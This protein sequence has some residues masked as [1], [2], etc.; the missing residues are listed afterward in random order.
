VL[1]VGAGIS[2]IQAAL[3]LAEM[4]VEVHLV[5]QTPSIGGR[6]PQLDKTFP[7]NDC[8]ICILAPKMTECARHPDIH[9]HPYSKLVSISGEP[10]NFECT[11]KEYARYVDP[12]KC[13]ACGN[14]EEKCPVKIVDEFDMGLRQRKVIY[15]YF[16][17]SVP[18]NYVIDAEHCLYLNKGV[19]RLCEK[20][21]PANAIKF[22]DEDRFIKINC[23]AIIIATGIDP[24]LPINYGQYGYRHFKDVVTSIEFERMLSASGPQKGHIIRPSDGTEP[25]RI[26]FVQC[27]GSRDSKNGN[28][29]C[30]SVCCMYAIKQAVIAKE[31][32]KEIEP[33]IFFMDIRAFG[34]DFD[35]YYER[36]KSQFG[37]NFVRARVAKITQDISNGNRLRL[38]FTQ[39]YGKRDSE[40]FDLVILSVGLIPRRSISE[41]SDRTDIRLDQYGFCR[42]L[43]FAPLE[44][45]RQGIFVCGAAGGPK[46]IPESVMS[47]SGAVASCARFLNLKRQEKVSKK[48]YPEEKDVTGERP[49]I[50][51][52]ICH[53]GINIAGVVDVNAVVE[54][55][56]TLPNVEYAQDVMYAC[57]QDS[58][59]TI[60]EMIKKHNLNRVLVAA[61]TPR[62][63][64][65]L[66]RE[67]LREAGLNQYLFEMA[68]IR[69]QCSW[70]HMQEPEAATAK[71]K[72]LVAMGVAKARNLSPLKRLSI[73]INPKALVIGAGLAGMTAARV[74]ADAGY[75]VCLLERDKELGGNFRRLRY[76]HLGEIVQQIEENKLIKVYKN[77]KLQ[78]IEGYIGNYKTTF[79]TEDDG[80]V[81]QVEHGVVIVATGARELRPEEYLY[82]KHKRVITQ[83]DFEK[84]ILNLPRY[85]NIVMIQCVGSREG[86]RLYCSR[87]CCSQAIKNALQVKK[88]HPN[89]EIYI[90]YRDIRT[91]G[92]M[93]KFYSQARDQGIIFIRYDLDHK[94][95]V[96][97]IE[98]EDPFGRLRVK[99][100]D[101]L[102]N[103]KI[104]IDADLLV[105]SAA[106]LAPEENKDLAKLL[107]VPL[108]KEGFFL[109]AHMKLRPV[110]FAT[111]GVFM[112]GLAHCP[113][114]SDESIIQASA[115]ASR[116]LTVLSKH[117]IES[118]GI[119]SWVNEVRCVGCGVCVSVC[120]YSAVELKEKE[121]MPKV[122]KSVAEVNEALCKGC[123][124]CAA[125]CRS[126]AINLAGVSRIQY[127]PNVRVIRVPC[128]GRVNPIF[129]LKALQNGFDGVLVSGCHPGDCHYISGNYVARRKFAMLKSLLEFIGIEPG[130]VQFSWVS[131]GEG[132][133]FATVINKVTQDVTKLGPVRRLKKNVQKGN[134]GD[135]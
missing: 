80:K 65:P 78:N 53:C 85:K 16:L 61:C 101:P 133:K 13:V 127:P 95:E 122:K 110:D 8:S 21:C 97:A 96:E 88:R 3:D 4:G 89:T 68:N 19:C 114:N 49:R 102:M 132:E 99:V 52:F 29:Y 72:D 60:K 94:P 116:A 75:E 71:A 54:F 9:L 20:A 39:E 35:K 130:R 93:E 126:G 6:M 111:D 32:I 73:E 23:R 135:D 106:I 67:T 134:D 38:H 124:A 44:T 113:K 81:H 83:L 56:K 74:I 69:D 70:A 129:I 100:V 17:Q 121:I 15:R 84:V 128:S 91:Y 108:N 57:S 103:K 10:G 63:H 118:E 62:T 47:A 25:R 30:S 42:T 92:L 22:E 112:C 117:Y 66:F 64:E 107:K 27:V 123:G 125:S 90:L 50:G 36:A 1:V 131:A 26:A 77:V 33:T 87:V 37:V 82:G 79:L 43:P 7:T 58:L 115:A 14:C 45:T 120:A 48:E 105:L 76:L 41:I 46:D 98:P 24:F 31:H 40:T 34:K 12:D 119:V 86:E 59:N 55:A 2:G 28:D 51:A 104:T 109:E 18:S 5:E 11:V